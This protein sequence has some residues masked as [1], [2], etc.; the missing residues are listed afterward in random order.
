M[1][2]IENIQKA[3]IRAYQ[4]TGLTS[5]AL[6]AWPNK[7]FTP[8]DNQ[9]HVYFNVDYGDV[10]VKT[11]GIGGQDGSDNGFVTLLLYYPQ[12][13]GT[14]KQVRDVDL[15]RQAFRAGTRLESGGTWLS[16]RSCSPS[17]GLPDGSYWVV[18]VT[19]SWFTRFG[20]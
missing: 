18:P 19:I 11:M 4:A 10:S 15:L 14:V 20:R 2:A 12:N 9:F 17:A 3:L 16:I 1:A 6:T 7:N 8:P 5:D 13:S